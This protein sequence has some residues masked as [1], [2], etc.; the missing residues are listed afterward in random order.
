MI[1]AQTKIFFLST[2]LILLFNLFFGLNRVYAASFSTSGGGT[3]NT[4]QTITVTISA[5]HSAAYNAVTANVNFSNLTYVSAS[6]TGGWTPVSGPERSGNTV[7]FSGA[8]LGSSATGTRG[9]MSITFRAPNSPGTATVSSSGTIALADG[10][11]TKLSAGGNAV[12]YTVRT[13]PT[14]PPPT[15]TPKPAPGPVTISSSTH[16]DQAQWYKSTDITFNWNQEAGVTDFSYALDNQQSTVPDDISEGNATTKTYSGQ[17]DGT[18]Y[19]HIK[20]KNEV[21]W[22]PVSH[23]A[24][25]I[26]TSS[27]DPFTPTSTKNPSGSYQLFFSTND[28]G[29]GALTY[30]V[31]A[32]DV[33]LGATTSGVTI[34]AGTK[35]VV[36]TA[37]D[38]AG[39]TQTSEI[40][41]EQNSTIITTPSNTNN[42]SN[43]NNNT[44]Q[45]TNSSIIPA[46]T[47]AL[48]LTIIYALVITGIYLTEKGFLDKITKRLDGTKSFGKKEE[49]VFE[50]SPIKST[51]KDGGR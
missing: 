3:V 36:I 10:S 1:K 45:N 19:F 26:D 42:T 49:K 46:L 16:P 24:V 32:D 11:G 7:S 50:E 29:S 33:D 14:P 47:I 27:P 15:P 23:F 21:G 41:L 40:N 35:S 4:G 2:S 18:Y 38:K 20:S 51:K 48:V 9:V 44:N 17:T 28:K 12:T 39:N 34:P 5:N 43:T 13:P 25:N 8:L 30:F 31:K 6:V 22:G 37:T